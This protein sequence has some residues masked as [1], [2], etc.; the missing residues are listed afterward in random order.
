M[1]QGAPDFV[2]PGSQADLALSSPLQ[3]GGLG[4]K[5]GRE[6]E[7]FGK[8][9]GVQGRQAELLQAARQDGRKMVSVSNPKTNS[10]SGRMSGGNIKGATI[11]TKD[12][13]AN[14]AFRDSNH[15]LANKGDFQNRVQNLS[16]ERQRQLAEMKQKRMQPQSAPN[17]PAPTTSTPK[18]NP[19]ST[20][21]TL[22]NNTTKTT[23][24]NVAKS[25]TKLGTGGKAALIGTGI[26]AAGALI[27]LSAI[28]IAK[29][30]NK[31]Y[32]V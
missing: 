21:K 25:G 29:K 14:I 3:E 13:G 31:F 30:H 24:N 16:P 17:P 20:P 12:G 7:M 4:R 15:A 28:T 18:P 9:K 1:G 5:A 23:T 27:A 11:V 19:N 6:F 10:I 8:A 32:R 2:R 22:V 26:L